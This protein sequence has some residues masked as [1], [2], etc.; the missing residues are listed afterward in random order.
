MKRSASTRLDVV[1]M[2]DD[3]GLAGTSHSFAIDL[4]GLPPARIQHT[5]AGIIA[6]RGRVAL[7]HDTA[8]ELS[9]CF[10]HSLILESCEAKHIQYGLV[11]QD[12]ASWTTRKLPLATGSSWP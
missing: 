1:A 8:V 5:I 6:D 12:R 11:Y 4:C 3:I 9:G 2:H 7:I 10:C